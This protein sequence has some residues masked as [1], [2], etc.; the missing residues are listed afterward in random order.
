MG[1]RAGAKQVASARWR[2]Q[3][4]ATGRR[5]HQSDLAALG[6]R[7][8]EEARRDFFGRPGLSDAKQPVLAWRRAL[9]LLGFL[10][11]N[12]PAAGPYFDD[13]PPGPRTAPRADERGSSGGGYAVLVWRFRRPLRRR[14]VGDR[15]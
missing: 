12:L 4:P 6:S 14:R 11:T 8:C 2:R 3:L 13:L 5:L 15:H 9:R 10:A 1:S 7:S